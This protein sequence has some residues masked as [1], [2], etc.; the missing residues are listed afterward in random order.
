MRVARPATQPAAV[1]VGKII[2]QLADDDFATRRVAMLRLNSLG[3]DALPAVTAAIEDPTT[4]AEAR[5]RL[6][7]AIQYLKPR[8]RLERLERERWAWKQ[9]QIRE[10]YTKY[11]ATDPRWDA[12]V[13][14]AIDRFLKMGTDPPNGPPEQREA[15]LGAFKEAVDRG[16]ND[17]YVLCL[18]HLSVGEKFH[19]GEGPVPR[20]FPEVMGQV[21]RGTM[22]PLIRYWV[23]VR[24]MRAIHE[25]GPDQFQRTANLLPEIAKMPGLPATELR[26]CAE[27]FFSAL[28]T[29][30]MDPWGGKR[31]LARAFGEAAPGTADALFVRGRMLIDWAW[32]ARGGGW[33]RDVDEARAKVFAERLADAEEALEAAW[34]LDP[35]DARIATL[36]ITVKL[37][38]GGGREAMETWFARAMEAD[39]D[40]VDA[41][42]RKLY[43]LYPR[44]YGDHAQM[45]AFGRECLKTE[46]WRAGV[47]FILVEAHLAVA[48]DGGDSKEYF[49][50]AE[51]WRD[52]SDVYEGCLTN[53]PEDAVRRSQ[54]ANFAA[55]CGHWDVADR[56]FRVLGDGAAADV[57]GSA[58]SM[59]YLRRKAARLAATMPSGAP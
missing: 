21:L 43:Y 26:A 24:Y 6:G 36:M 10:A 46:N 44:W 48:E 15:T 40:A 51:V 52:L 1:D 17:P 30:D 34:K 4:A 28:E 54:Y 37:G 35:T 20:T 45:I 53:F 32:E 14:A 11:G 58:S 56:Q 18:Y 25:N 55:K 7:T 22:P 19:R 27:Q 3:G 57:F 50:R 23:G 33:A 42:V 8:A 41:C 49:A 13:M 59:N 5:A 16:C 2:S 47:P 12:Q 39:P 31:T 9:A 38:R 29:F